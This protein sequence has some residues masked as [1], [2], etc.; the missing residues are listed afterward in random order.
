M[1]K[2]ERNALAD[3]YIAGGASKS[4]T[5]NYPDTPSTTT[6]TGTMT[7]TVT[8]NGKTVVNQVTTF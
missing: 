3:A 4:L 2:I 1:L 5:V 6:N 8:I 7:N